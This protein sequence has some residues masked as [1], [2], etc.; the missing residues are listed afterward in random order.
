M[1]AFLGILGARLGFQYLDPIAGL[2][3]SAL[4]IKMSLTLFRSNIGILMDEK[5]ETAVLDEIRA[6]A[7]E[8]GGVQAI[9]S[10]KVHRR[11]S[12]FTID[13]EVAVDCILTVEQGHQV[14]N[15][16]RSKLLGKVEHVQDVMVHVNP[17]QPG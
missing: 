9:D 8:V 5:P 17:Y 15:E 3:V 10:L 6:L 16:V 12:N 14:A 7:L 2:A 13:I 1:A 4:I 11:G